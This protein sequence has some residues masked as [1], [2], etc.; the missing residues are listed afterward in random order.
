MVKL[1]D[2]MTKNPVT[3]DS[4]RTVREAVNIMVEKKLGS[5]MVCK[6]RTGEIIGIIEEANIVRDVLARDLNPYVVKVKE[7]MS[8]PFVI[9]EEKSDNEASDLMSQH[10]VRHLAVSSN[11]KIVGIVS[12][13]DL[14]R[15]VYAGKSFWI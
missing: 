10:E 13:Q 5:L 15:P 11:S 14:I 4:D 9:D 6:E 8:V 1:K 3:V 2:I 12:M 7:V